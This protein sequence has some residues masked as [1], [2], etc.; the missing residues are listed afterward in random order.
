MND[1]VQLANQNVLQPAAR[2]PQDNIG[3]AEHGHPGCLQDVAPAGPRLG[4]HALARVP[5]RGRIW[6]HEQRHY[7]PRCVARPT[8]GLIVYFAHRMGSGLC[9]VLVCRGRYVFG[10][11][12]LDF[13]LDLNLGKVRPDG[14][15]GW[16][17]VGVGV[18]SRP[19]EARTFLRS[20]TIGDRPSKQPRMVRTFLK[21]YGL[22][23]VCF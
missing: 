14:V 21:V 10:G 17:E 7:T 23:S 12:V 3:T 13:I 1:H 19:G 15:F 2:R 4:R 5:R 22:G 8:P 9:L 18:R 16:E 20:H 6:R 11:V